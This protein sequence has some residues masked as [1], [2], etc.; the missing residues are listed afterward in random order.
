MRSFVFGFGQG[1]GEHMVQPCTERHPRTACCLLRETP[2]IRIDAPQGPR[3][4]VRHVNPSPAAAR[5]SVP[6][7]IAFPAHVAA[8]AFAGM[9]KALPRIVNKP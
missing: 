3:M 5:L 4:R 7:G 9:K 8:D 1:F 2:E 6:R